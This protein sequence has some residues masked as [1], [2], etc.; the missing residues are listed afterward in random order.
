MWVRMKEGWN[1]AVST[2]A[3]WNNN[4]NSDSNNNGK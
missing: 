2:S 4:N 1:S 3:V